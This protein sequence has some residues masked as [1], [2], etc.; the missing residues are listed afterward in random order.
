MKLMFMK[1]PQTVKIALTAKQKIQ[2]LMTDIGGGWYMEI[3][4]G[5]YHH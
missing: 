1:I 2:K 4:L 5:D 3:L